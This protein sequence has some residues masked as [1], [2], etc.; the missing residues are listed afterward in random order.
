MTAKLVVVLLLTLLSLGIFGWRIARRIRALRWGQPSEPFR[1]WSAR[2]ASVLNFF[3]GQ[4]RLF[5]VRTP[6]LAHFLIFWGFLVLFPTIVQAVLEGLFPSFVLPFFA[7]FGPLTLVQDLFAIMVL[8]AILHGLYVRVIARPARYEGSHQREG[9]LVLGFIFLIMSSFLVLNGVRMNLGEANVADARWQPISNAI[10]GGLADLRVETQHL[11]HE[12]A[13][14]IHLVVVLAFLALLPVGKHFHVVTSLFSVFL[15]NLEPPGRLP[16]VRTFDGIPGVRQIEHFSWRQML[17]W[18]SCTECGRCQDVCPSH[19]SGLHISPKTFI[20]SLRDHLYTYGTAR[21]DAGSPAAESRDSIQ[22]NQQTGTATLRTVPTLVGEA[23]PDELIW[24]CTTCLACDQECPLFLEHVTP[25]VDIRRYLLAEQRADTELMSALQSLRRYGNSFG[26]SERQRA[27]WT[28]AMK[29][30]KIKDIRKQPAPVLWFVGDYASYSPSL[31]EATMATARVLQRSGLDFGILYDAE[32]N[33]G[34]DVRRIGEEGLYELLSMKNRQVLNKCEFE[35]IVTTDPHSYNTLKNEYVFEGNG[36]GRA[37]GNGAP[38][39]GRRH[40]PVLH[41]SEL[42]ERELV[43]GKL[44]VHQPIH[45]RVTYHDPCYLGRYNGIYDAPRRVLERIGCEIVEMPCHRDRALCCGAGGGRIWMDESKVK[46]RP[47]E[48]RIREAAS[49]PGVGI[50][51]TACPKDLTMYRDAVKTVGIEDRLEVRDLV[52]LVER[53]TREPAEVAG[54]G[55]TGLA[56][57]SQVVTKEA[58]R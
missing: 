42:L 40:V 34:N 39:G 33:A 11:I 43:A 54:D 1:D 28:K 23:I 30:L 32:R 22:Q 7:T 15:R 56:S 17:D 52:E 58:A 25:L 38:D 13:Y 45:E 35:E 41:I 36:R 24:G 9:I 49:L 20:L 50:F 12:I 48:T 2:F 53:A 31:A 8:G 14:W 29:P 5:R 3:L 19:L 10:G 18:Y 27:I 21:A 57:S 4:R 46:Q 51:V 44:V 6:G 55:S 26:K 37:G 16:P 47:S